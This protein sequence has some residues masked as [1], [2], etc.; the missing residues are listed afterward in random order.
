LIPAAEVTA[1]NI[2]TGIVT[3]QISNETGNYNF[4]SLQPGTYRVSASLPGFRT[5]TFQ[6]VQLSQAQ[7]VR[8]NFTLEVAAAGETVDVTAIGDTALATTSASVGAVLPV[9]EVRSLPLAV[10]DVLGLLN[11]MPGASGYNFGGAG[12]R[13]LNMTRDGLVVNDTRYGVGNATGSGQNGTYMSPDLVEEV[14]VIVGNVDAE[15]GRGSGQVSLQTRSGTNQFHGAL[16]YFNNNSALNANDYFSNLTGKSKA[17]LNRNQYG[18]RLGGPILK[19]KAFFFVLIDNQRYLQKENFVATVLTDPARNG[20]FR[21]IAGQ[22]NGNALSATASVDQRGNILNPAGLRSFDLFKDVQDPLRTGISTNSYWRYVLGQMPLPNDY[23]VGDGLNTA[24]FRWQRPIKGLGGGNNV[25]NENNRDQLNLRFDYQLS[26]KNK[27]TFTTSREEDWGVTTNLISDWPGGFNGSNQ[28]FPH[29][30]TASWTSTISPSVLNEFR[31]GYKE[32]SYHRRAPFQAGCCF[33]DK[34]DD[35]SDEAQKAFDLLPKTNGYVLYPIGSGFV[36]GSGGANTGGNQNLMKHG[37]DLTRGQ[38]SPTRQFSDTISWNKSS[39]SFKA[40]FEYLKAWSN[41]WNTTSEQTPT[42]LFGNGNF[43]VSAITSTRFAGLN[44]ND[45]TNAVALLNDLSGSIGGLT[46]GRVINS[47]TQTSW[48]DF[49]GDPR[50][51]RHLTQ[52]DWDVFFKDSWNVTKNLTLNIGMRYDKFG[53]L[54]DQKGMLPRAKGGQAALFNYA[55]NGTLTESI[56]VGKNSPNSGELFW[57]NDWNN[58]G[59]TVGFSYRVPWLG[60]TTVV[61]GGYGINYAGA[62]VILDYENDF[63]N[64]PGGADVYLPASPFVPT[65]YVNLATA[66]SSNVIPL[67]AKTQPGLNVAIPLADKTQIMNTP[68]DNRVTP[69]IQSFNFGIQREIMQGLTLDVSYIGNKGSKLFGR[70][71]VNE[72]ELVANGMLDAF[73]TTRSGGNA[74]LFNRLLNGLNVPGVGV[75]NGTTLTG[76]EAFRRWASTR[77][78]LANGSVAQFANFVS[79]TS[80]LT[81]VNG[82]LL[83]N[84]GLPQNFVTASPQFSDAQIWETGRASTYHSLQVQTRKRFT[85]GFTGQFAY[86]WSR[87]IGDAVATEVGVP[88]TIDPKRKALNKGRLNFD[89]THVFNAN[90]TWELPFGPGKRF[91]AGGPGW[92]HRIVEGWQLSSIF[93]HYTGDPVNVS[94]TVRTMGSINN[95]SLPNIAGDFPKSLGQVRKGAGFVEYFSGISSQPAP[96]A[97][98]YGSDANNLASFATLFNVVDSSGKVLLTNPEPGRV[99]TLGTRWIT[100]PAQTRFDISMAKRFQIREKTNFTFRADA[101]NAFNLTNWGNPN[102]NVN[103]KNFGRISGLA[104]GTTARQLTL[105]LRVDF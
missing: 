83:T 72:P 57:P 14:Q 7:Q 45:I 93:S 67:P 99:G 5:Q 19:N 70:Y 24:G 22:Q 13:A 30:Y 21:Y 64:T 85:Q 35:R 68:S 27:L 17:F 47:P 42:A 101:I 33:A 88:T 37:F 71:S 66:L 102:V 38:K 40:G 94:S 65:S 11:T 23:T 12:T 49:L 82:G 105:S 59:P 31:Y 2:N 54:Y 87:A 79:T 91:I 41:G 43:P 74:A 81:N 60:R 58:F 26:S 86:T 98:L 61:R 104:N 56:L 80:S 95:L 50:R 32:T 69:Y 36:F 62:L 100:G 52:Q 77:V 51:F 97:G 16:F 10:R 20:I 90:G 53:V 25:G 63:G 75:V 44:S 48:D 8:L 76:S 96:T 28:Y 34:W 15:A 73:V 6:D 103:D 9:Q 84:A 55:R 18:G 78:F 89:H 92:L 39:H 29:L 1:S 3:T 46:F 4:A